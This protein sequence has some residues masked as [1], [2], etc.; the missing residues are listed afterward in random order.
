M[1]QDIVFFSSENEFEISSRKP[2]KGF[3][4][5]VPHTNLFAIHKRSFVLRL[6]GEEQDEKFKNIGRKFERKD[7]ICVLLFPD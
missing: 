1:K 5:S 7:W 6:P 3:Y 2:N 4:F